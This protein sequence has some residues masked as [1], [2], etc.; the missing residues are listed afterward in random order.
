MR[1]IHDV[2]LWF[3]IA[4]GSVGLV[5]FWVPALTRK[6]GP[7]HRKAGWVYVWAML[8]VVATAVI[9]AALLLYDPEAAHEFVGGPSEKQA[10]GVAQARAVA[11]LFGALALLTLTNGWQGLQVLRAKRNPLK[12]RTAFNVGLHASN[13]MVGVPLIRLGVCNGV[14]LFVVF[15]VLCLVTGATDLRSLWRPSPDPQYWLFAHLNGMIATGIAAHTAFLTLGALRLVPQL[16]TLSP[17]LYGIPWIGPTVIGAI[18]INLLQ[19]HY[20]RK[21][22]SVEQPSGGAGALVERPVATDAHDQVTT[23]S[24]LVVRP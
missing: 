22:R 16:Y 11:L 24:D 5:A 18:A 13:V 2:V 14:P 8:G 23:I 21:P 12:L 4:C 1:A 6:G 17:V 15:G 10:A 9:L 3:H 20:R 7:T 19:R